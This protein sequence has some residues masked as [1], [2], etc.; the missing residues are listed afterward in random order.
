MRSRRVN[1]NSKTSTSRSFH[2][3]HSVKRSNDLYDLQND[4]N[5]NYFKSTANQY[6]LNDEAEETVNTN[7]YPDSVK[8]ELDWYF[9]DKQGRMNI[10][11]YGNR[12]SKEKYK[13]FITSNLDKNELTNSQESSGRS[14]MDAINNELAYSSSA[15]Y[16]QSSRSSNFYYKNDNNNQ[17]TYYLNTIIESEEDEGVYQCINP[18]LPNFILR[19]VT[20]LLESK[21]TY[22]L[23][24]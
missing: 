11:S 13:T 5:S 9:L 21:D 15:L 22:F 4:D 7:I 17:Y 18:D 19:N 3:K 2:H 1:T 23:I 24:F 8:Y 12:T 20:I 14:R 16:S 6:V 10:I